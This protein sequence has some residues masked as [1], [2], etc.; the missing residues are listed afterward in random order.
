[1]KLK[2]FGAQ[3]GAV[4]EHLRGLGWAAVQV[5]F[6]DNRDGVIVDGIR[7][8]GH[9]VGFSISDMAL[10]SLPTAVGS[11]ALLALVDREAGT[12]PVSTCSSNVES[13]LAKFI[14]STFE[15]GARR[16]R[17]ALLGRPPKM[18]P[19]EAI[20]RLADVIRVVVNAWATD[21]VDDTMRFAA[22]IE[23]DL[24]KPPAKVALPPPKPPEWA[25]SWRQV[26]DLFGFEPEE[27][28]PEWHNQLELT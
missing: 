18:S 16:E 2:Q 25:R 27:P 15:E 21:V 19:L 11:D 9:R 8:C 24:N 14:P 22:A 1:M 12:C 10:Y 13:N 17:D 4:E 3:F 6:R 7:P 20:I 26:A 28:A 23:L 5:A